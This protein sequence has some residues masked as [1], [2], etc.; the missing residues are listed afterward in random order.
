MKTL[1]IIGGIAPESTVECYR[2][3]IAIHR[4]RTGGAYPQFV[5]NSID[6]TKMLGFINENRRVELVEF[7]IGELRKLVAAGAEIGMLASNTPH[8]V[9]DELRAVSPLP[10]IS[11]VEAA[12]DAADGSRRL[13]L[14]GTRS[15]M[16]AS[17]Y[18]DVFAKRGIEV[19]SPDDDD[20]EF[21]HA[22]YMD[23]LVNGRFLPETREQILA[24]A[25]RMLD[26]QAIDGVILGG[27]EL[28]LLLRAAEWDGLR[29]LDTGRVHA[30]AAVRA[31]LAD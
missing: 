20:L 11:I 9:F 3:I 28:P 5:I 13:A 23:E 6:L 22:K 4:E 15:T 1:G 27:T 18:R 10:L 26:R 31:M 29:F 8:L 17:F 19:V 25:A 14:F 16:R 30:E 2:S 12:A 7:L 24:V 21:I